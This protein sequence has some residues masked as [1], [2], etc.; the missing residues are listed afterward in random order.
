MHTYSVHFRSQPYFKSADPIYCMFDIHRLG[1]WF[2]LTYF[3]VLFIHSG[4]KQPPATRRAPFRFL[5][6][7]LTISSK[8]LRIVRAFRCSSGLASTPRRFWDLHVPKVRPLH[9]PFLLP[10]LIQ[11]CAQ[12]TWDFRP[13]L[14]L[15]KTRRIDTHRT[16]NW[17]SIPDANLPE[18]W[19]C[20]WAHWPSL[21]DL[22]R[23]ETVLPMRYKISDEPL[24]HIMFGCG[25][26]WVLDGRR[27]TILACPAT[28]TFY[29]YRAP[30]ELGDPGYQAEE[31]WRFEGVFPSVGAFIEMAD[32]NRVEKIGGD[33]DDKSA[34]RFVSKNIDPKF[35]ATDGRVAANE[36]YSRRTFWDMYRPP[37]DFEGC[38]RAKGDSLDRALREWPHIPDSELAQPWSCQWEFFVETEKWY[39]YDVSEAKLLV[40]E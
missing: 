22:P 3:T 29:M 17:G 6:L 20:D 28:T 30:D 18:P 40:E 24:L 19:S 1:L 39:G 16:R 36:P 2:P 35:L 13:R 34:V 26:G 4:L 32:W 38:V 27:V 5:C 23:V 7:T 31:M 11:P 15:G 12:P 9:V 14:R 37:R 8:P 25:Y 33:I 21:P 10:L